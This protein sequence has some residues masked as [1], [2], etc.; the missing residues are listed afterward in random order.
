VNASYTTLKANKTLKDATFIGANLW[1][2]DE[3]G[4]QVRTSRILHRWTETHFE[5]ENTNYTVEFLEGAECTVPR[6][7]E[8]WPSHRLDD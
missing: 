4:K 2:T 5:T 6:H 3:N 1:G 7:W 8:K